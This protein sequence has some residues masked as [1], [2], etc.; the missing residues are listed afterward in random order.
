MTAKQLF[1]LILILFHNVAYG[2]IQEFNIID[3]LPSISQS[4]LAKRTGSSIAI[5]LRMKADPGIYTVK[6]IRQGAPNQIITTRDRFSHEGEQEFFIKLSLDEGNNSFALTLMGFSQAVTPVTTTISNI[7]RDLEFNV[8]NLHLDHVQ[9]SNGKVSLYTTESEI[10][11]HYTLNGTASTYEIKTF[12]NGTEVKSDTIFN[13]GSGVITNIPLVQ[14]QLNLIQLKASVL[15][16]GGVNLGTQ[17]DSDFLRMFHDTVAPIIT[18]VSTT[19]PGGNANPAGPTDLAVFGLVIE[20]NEPFAQIQV[21]N[22]RNSTRLIRM[23]D[24][25]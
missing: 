23:T 14:N 16:A 13:A 18:G 19:L 12:I 9:E 15:D 11:A 4:S 2:A 10:Q 7:F 21:T 25:S 5:K 6:A 17:K 20:T 8:T 3:V 22:T 24:L 1:V